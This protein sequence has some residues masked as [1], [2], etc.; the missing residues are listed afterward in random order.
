MYLQLSSVSISWIQPRFSGKPNSDLS[1][2]Y[3]PLSDADTI[4]PDGD[5]VEWMIMD[6]MDMEKYH[7][8][9][10]DYRNIAIVVF[11]GCDSV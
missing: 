10:F 3:R 4:C 7:F 5:T 9:G 2:S 8:W 11:L 6:G 1:V